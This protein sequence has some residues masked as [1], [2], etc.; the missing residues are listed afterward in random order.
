VIPDDVNGREWYKYG[1]AQRGRQ[2]ERR[3]NQP[4]TLAFSPLRGAR[5]DVFALLQP[6]EPTKLP[7]RAP[8]REGGGD[9]CCLVLDFPVGLAEDGFF[10]AFQALV[11]DGEEGAVGQLG[12]TGVTK[13]CALAIF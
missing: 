12:G 2:I 3:V 4:L 10:V 7:V 1:M 5:E 13:V 8:S 11:P 6:A 9:D